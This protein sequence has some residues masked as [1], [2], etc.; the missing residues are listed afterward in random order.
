LSISTVA[1]L[2]IFAVLITEAGRGREKG[3]KFGAGITSDTAS[4][5]AVSGYSASLTNSSISSF[6]GISIITN[7]GRSAV[8]SQAPA[9]ELELSGITRVTQSLN[10]FGAFTLE[11]DQVF[12]VAN[13]TVGVLGRIAR[14]PARRNIRTQITLAEGS[15]SN[16]LDFG[17]WA[18]IS[19]K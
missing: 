16:T 17:P 4:V 11:T 9:A 8:A 5:I 7:S 12:L 1:I 6:G 13:G 2:S 10:S 18:C 14:S 19:S 15:F 3:T